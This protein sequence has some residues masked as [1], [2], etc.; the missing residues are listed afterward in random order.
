M[1]SS[2]DSSLDAV[3]LASACGLDYRLLRQQLAQ[4][5][6]QAADQLT[7]QLLCQAA[8]SLAAKRGWL[9]FTE[10]EGIPA[11]DLRTLDQLWLKSANG[12]FGFSV[13]R[14]LWLA[15]NK[16]WDKLWPIIGWKQGNH[17]TR[18]PQEFTW[19]PSAPKGH[20]PLSNQLRGVQ[21][22]AALLNHPAWLEGSAAGEKME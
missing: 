10:V 14:Q 19:D 2:T 16:D 1:P 15:V 21:V 7:L 13:Q 8:G 20:L 9:Y 11:E 18:Y 17:W 6:F 12:K 22:M 4:Q 5:Q 3:V